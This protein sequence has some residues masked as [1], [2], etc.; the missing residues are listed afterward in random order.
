MKQNMQVIPLNEIC[1][2]S[3]CVRVFYSG[4]CKAQNSVRILQIICCVL[5][6]NKMLQLQTITSD[7]CLTGMIYGMR[8]LRHL[9][10]N[11]A[12]FYRAKTQVATEIS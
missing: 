5:C 3:I 8:P 6:Q 4:E 11:F 10:W 7:C 2:Y 12:T 9:C 1:F